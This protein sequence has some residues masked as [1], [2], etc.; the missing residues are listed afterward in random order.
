MLLTVMSVLFAAVS[1]QPRN[2]YIHDRPACMPAFLGNLDG[3]VEKFIN[4]NFIYPQDAWR[5]QKWNE[6]VV[7]LLV[8]ADGN[9][10][11]FY[12]ENIKE[13]PHPL[14]IAEMERVIDKMEWK[15]GYE[16][17]SAVNSYTT[18]LFP[19]SSHFPKY[20]YRIPTGMKKQFEQA[21]Y[22]ACEW[23]F[24]EKDPVPD[25]QK[26]QQ[27]LRTMEK[28]GI[29]FS[30]SPQILTGLIRA[31]CSRNR[32]GQAVTFADNSLE[33]YQTRYETSSDP[34]TGITI[35]MNKA[36]NY[37][38]RSEAWLGALRAI[39]HDYVSGAPADTFYDA[40]IGLIDARIADGYLYPTDYWLN[41][42]GKSQYYNNLKSY[43]RF[44][45][46]DEALCEEIAQLEKDLLCGQYAT[47]DEQLNLFGAKAMLVWLR[48]GYEGMRSYLA[49]LR[50]GK[51]SGKLKKYLD[52]LEKRYNANSATLSDRRGVVE[53]LACYVP[54]GFP[55]DDERSAFYGRRRAFTDVFPISWL[56]AVS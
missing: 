16:G 12:I 2:L 4:K 44:H 31:L 18:I 26:E 45:P 10:E 20:N 22:H 32:S 28:N 51:L 53:A 3:D 39:I 27:A 35:K 52:R 47:N 43:M 38:G 33:E 5:V 11:E 48:D 1:V 23:G 29:F 17:I 14:L 9:V 37:S 36:E 50:G 7:S 25:E 30:D 41:P 8:K 21:W 55:T 15:P 19:F 34:V 13:K 46:F 40:A 42:K 24:N 49:E 56:F 6:A 54:P